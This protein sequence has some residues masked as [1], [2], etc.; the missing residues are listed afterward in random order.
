M[1]V[2][3]RACFS[4]P[5]SFSSRVNAR[6]LKKSWWRRDS[7]PQTSDLIHDE[8]DHR[9][10]VPCSESVF[11]WNKKKCFTEFSF[12]G[13]RQSW[14]HNSKKERGKTLSLNGFIALHSLLVLFDNRM[15]FIFYFPFH[16]SGIWKMN[17]T[18][19]RNI[20]QCEEFFQNKKLNFILFK[21]IGRTIQIT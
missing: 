20:F 3:R 16:V 7:N 19:Q 21:F 17:S 18:S 12:F 10:M 6:S 8:L 11:V 13:K 15:S 4:F 9:A 5:S 2:R 14:D 1:V